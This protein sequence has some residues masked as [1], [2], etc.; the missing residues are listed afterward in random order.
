MSFWDRL[1]FIVRS[2]L[3]AG[4]DKNKTDSSKDSDFVDDDI[5]S[6]K[7]NNLVRKVVGLPK[8]VSD[9]FKVLGLK[10]TSDLDI[11]KKHYLGLMKKYHPDR[12]KNKR[13]WAQKKCSSINEAYDII[14]K[15]YQKKVGR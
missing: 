3:N 8:P 7:F 10:P 2:Y 13:D 4:E 12:N 6:D 15:Y 1:K 5:L 9:A 11:I 14:V